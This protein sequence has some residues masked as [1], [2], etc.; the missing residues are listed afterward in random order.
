MVHSGPFEDGE[1]ILGEIPLGEK[2]EKSLQRGD[3]SSFI[4]NPP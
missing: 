4:C 2:V 3:L 1:E